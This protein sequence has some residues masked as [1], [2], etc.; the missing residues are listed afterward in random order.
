MR[1][2]RRRCHTHRCVN[3]SPIIIIGIIDGAPS[4]ILRKYFSKRILRSAQPLMTWMTWFVLLVIH[5]KANIF[6]GSLVRFGSHSEHLV[7]F[8]SHSSSCY[9]RETFCF[10]R[11]Q[12]PWQ[13]TDASQSSSLTHTHTHHSIDINLSK[14]QKQ[15]T[16]HIN[17]SFG[18]FQAKK[19][20]SSSSSNTL[21]C[22]SSVGHGKR[23]S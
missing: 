15:I 12:L 2:R 13:L 20:K 22:H 5:I 3:V 19:R 10:T 9:R 11:G 7:R 17:P 8:R 23:D 18:L 16:M 14:Q 4:N 21:R 6:T 1:T